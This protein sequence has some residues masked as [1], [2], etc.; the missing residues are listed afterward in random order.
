MKRN[1][2]RSCG[3]CWWY[4]RM[5]SKWSA[6][7]GRDFGGLC[8]LK[9]GRGTPQVQVYNWCKTWTGIKYNKIKERRNMKILLK[10]GFYDF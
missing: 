2:H 8:L 4:Q 3:N 6:R 9:D 7:I 10:R 5:H 1:F